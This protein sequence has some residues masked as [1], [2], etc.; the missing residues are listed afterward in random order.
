M[1][2]DVKGVLLP[3]TPVEVVANTPV[4]PDFPGVVPV[5]LLS[6]PVVDPYGSSVVLSGSL[7][8]LPAS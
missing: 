7:V 6:A 2:P 3:L 5:V 1:E 8:V 4:V